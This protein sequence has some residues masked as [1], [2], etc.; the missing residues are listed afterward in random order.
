[1][2]TVVRRTPGRAL[3]TSAGAVGDADGDGDGLLATDYTRTV[4][5]WNDGNGS[6]S[7][8]PLGLQ[9]LHPATARVDATEWSSSTSRSGNRL[10]FQDRRLAR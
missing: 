2:A 10:G 7:P 8:T 6:L 3:A 5:L 1:M 9:L 4:V